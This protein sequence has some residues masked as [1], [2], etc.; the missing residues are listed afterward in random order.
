MSVK[1]AVEEREDSVIEL[2]S[3]FFQDFLEMMEPKEQVVEQP[4]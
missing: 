1:D 3:D 2:D 4:A